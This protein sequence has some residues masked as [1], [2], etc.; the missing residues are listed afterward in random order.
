M[1]GSRPRPPALQQK[2][3]CFQQASA[4][5]TSPCTEA[6]MRQSTGIGIYAVILLI[7]ACCA[8]KFSQHAI[9]WLIGLTASIPIF[10][11]IS[12]AIPKPKE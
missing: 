8:L 7:A 4:Q 3:D 1:K 10:A 6:F 5:Y 9:A 11:A 12:V 2:N